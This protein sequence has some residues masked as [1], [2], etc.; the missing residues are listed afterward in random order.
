MNVIGLGSAGCAM[1]DALDEYPQY[2]IYKLD[3]GLPRKGNTYPIAERSS[4]EEYDKNPPKLKQF[5]S[6]M[7]QSKSLL[8]IMGGGGL[9]SGASLQVLQQL[10]KKYPKTIDIM[11]IKPDHE[12]IS[13]IAYKRDRICYRVL[14]EYVRSGVF[15]SMIL[16]SNPHIEAAAGEIPLKN[17]YKNLNKFIASAYHMVNVF[18][19]TQSVMSSIS[20]NREEHVRIWT[21]GI[22]DAEKKEEKMFFPLDKPTEKCYYYGINEKR[23]ETDGKLLNEV[24]K[25]VKENSEKAG[26]PCSY[27]IHSTL[28]DRDMAYVTCW[29]S[30]VQAYPEIYQSL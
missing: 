19:H 21:L 26:T 8:F 29:S 16:L 30:Q 9:I 22:F 14:Q 13:D 4:H 23:I 20:G 3:N 1:A 2:N 28:Y 18:S 27:A 7:E 6:R 25:Q 12:M 10:H 11:Y 24:R 17:Y 5:I 15:R